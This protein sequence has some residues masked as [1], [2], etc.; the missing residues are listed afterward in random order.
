MYQ[1]CLFDIFLKPPGP[2]S[3]SAVDSA[4]SLLCRLLPVLFMGPS[5]VF[6]YI[7]KE[8]YGNFFYK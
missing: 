1:T 5:D 2:D 7:G 6:Q 8:I 3:V 4:C